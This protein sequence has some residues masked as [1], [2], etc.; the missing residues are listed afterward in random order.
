[1]KRFLLVIDTNDEVKEKKEVLGNFCL[2]LLYRRLIHRNV[3]PEEKVLTLL[4]KLQKKLPC[5]IIS[6]NSVWNLGT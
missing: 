6:Q 2:Y 3:Q 5:I 1:M 4:W